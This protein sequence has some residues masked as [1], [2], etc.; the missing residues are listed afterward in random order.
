VAKWF[1]GDVATYFEDTTK[2]ISRLNPQPLPKPPREEDEPEWPDFYATKVTEI[3]GHA[4]R[5]F[6]PDGA[7]LDPTDP[8]ESTQFGDGTGTPREYVYTTEGVE[9]GIPANRFLCAKLKVQY[10][11]L[12]Y[13]LLDDEE[14]ESEIERHVQFIPEEGQVDYITVP[15]STQ[16]YIDS[17]GVAAGNPAGHLVPVP[18]PVGLTESSYRFT[19]RWH[20]I[21][22]DAYGPGKPLWARIF[23]DGT[24]AN[25]PYLNA[26][27]DTVFYFETFP[28]GTCMLEKVTEKIEP[29]LIDSNFYLWTIDFSFRVVP[30]GHN[31]QWYFPN[32]NEWAAAGNVAKR[33]FV[34]RG[35]TYYAPGSVPDLRANYVEREL[36]DLF[37]VDDMV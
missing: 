13:Q 17:A 18:Y 23:G 8:E 32:A 4:W 2:K 22:Y 14:T 35:T 28:I 15:A 33:M 24:T 37:N 31:R 5:D 21:P 27:N 12:P 1:V 6:D 30:G 34:A 9:A 26:V 25:L 20:R 11:R 7:V 36:E 19:L 29:S 10:E 16:N 3:T